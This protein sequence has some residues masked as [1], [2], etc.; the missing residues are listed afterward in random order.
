[1]DVILIIILPVLIG[2]IADM[3]F[4]DPI[5]L[6]HP[7]VGFGKIISWGEKKLN[8]KNRRKL[9]GSFFSVGLILLTFIITF[10]FID[11]LSRIHSYLGVLVSSIIVFYC[12]AGKTLVTEV[13][14]TFI[15]V[16]ESL[17]LG[18]ISISRIVGRDTSHLNSQQI[19]TAALETLSENLSDGVIAPLFWFMLLGAPGMLAYKMVNTLDSMIGYK[20]KRYKDFGCWAARIDDIA[21]YIPA[22]LTSLLMIVSGGCFSAISFVRKYGRRHAS[23]NSGYPEAAL[24]GI[25]NCKFGGPNIYFGKIVDKPY[26]GD[27]AKVLTSEDMKIAVSINRRSEILMVFLVIFGSIFIHYTSNLIYLYIH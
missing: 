20:S 22:R 2:W 1:M 23:P 3:I 8:R 14:N 26:I 7:V 13:K 6:P 5:W 16:N 19:R 12:L 21:N 27:N 4:G 9:K 15:A 17:E 11:L 24:A 10:F 18:R 25:L